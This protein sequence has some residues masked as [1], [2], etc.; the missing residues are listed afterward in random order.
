MES[1]LYLEKV[2]EK[3]HKLSKLF[4]K[5]AVDIAKKEVSA[6]LA[7]ELALIVDNGRTKDVDKVRKEL[8]D[9]V[10]KSN[11]PKFAYLYARDIP[12]ADIPALQTIV[13]NSE[14]PEYA[15]EFA[16]DIS[17]IDI[18]KLQSIV[19]SSKNAFYAYRFAKYVDNADVKS[20]ENVVAKSEDVNIIENFMNDIDGVNNRRLNRIKNNILKN[21]I[22]PEENEF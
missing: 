7:Y 1:N 16:S 2:K 12:K 18:T 15:T 10:V 14:N 22:Q 19:V 4:I 21:K 11:N 5:S 13:E 20:L 9:V 17:G 3:G 8:C 6:E